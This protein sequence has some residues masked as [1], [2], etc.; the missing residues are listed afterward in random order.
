M[1]RN[2]ILI[3]AALLFLLLLFS[4]CGT[5]AGSQANEVAT[6]PPSSAS[7]EQ[8]AQTMAQEALN[9][10]GQAHSLSG[11]YEYETSYELNEK[12]IQTTTQ[13]RIQI[14]DITTLPKK[15]RLEDVSVQMD[16]ELLSQL[17]E[18]Y[19]FQQED[20]TLTTYT[21][22]EGQDGK[23]WCVDASE[24]LGGTSPYAPLNPL[25]QLE[26][27]NFSKEGTEP[28][29]EQQALRLIGSVSAQPFSFILAPNTEAGM[30]KNLHQDSLPCTLWIDEQTGTLLQIE[31]LMDEALQKSAEEEE[32]SLPNMRNQK[33]RVRL[34]IDEVNGSYNILVPDSF[35]E[36]PSDFS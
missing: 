1:K 20:G 9:K 31:V 33:A 10:L 23:T 16:G 11:E 2:T 17:K 14:E 7:V 5:R 27:Q 4:G 25:L 28:F 30:P 26:A 8:D 35:S 3:T 12:T 21:R 22:A 15:I 36:Q 24:T 34:R 32:G 29:L 6:E 18:Q 13:A 19:L